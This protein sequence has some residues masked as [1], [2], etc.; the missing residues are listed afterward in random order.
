[1]NILEEN[2]TIWVTIKDWEL[3][4]WENDNVPPMIF[5]KA[6]PHKQTALSYLVWCILVSCLEVFFEKKTAH[7]GVA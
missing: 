7:I 3:K 1:M 2:V 5:L 6:L 4:P